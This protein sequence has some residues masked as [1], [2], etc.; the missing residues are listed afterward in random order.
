[1]MEIRR[2]VLLI[3][4]LL[5]IIL[6]L[7]KL[8]EFFQINVVEADASKFVSEDLRTKYPSADIEIM[9]ITTKYNLEGVKYSSSCILN[10]KLAKSILDPFTSYG[11][12]ESSCFLSS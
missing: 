3:A 7:V 5:L 6:A 1:M 8:V 12:K 4:L 2:E 11:A 10:L 9:T